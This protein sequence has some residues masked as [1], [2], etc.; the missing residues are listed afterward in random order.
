MDRRRRESRQRMVNDQDG[1]EWVNVSSGTGSPGWSETNGRQRSLLLCL[2]VQLFLR[3]FSWVS[4]T[5]F[6][7][8]VLSCFFAQLFHEHTATCRAI[9]KPQHQYMHCIT[10][11]HKQATATGNVKC[12]VWYGCQKMLQFSLFE[13][14]VQCVRS[15]CS[16][17]LQAALK[18]QRRDPAS[19][20]LCT[21]TAQG[22]SQFGTGQI[23][24]LKRGASLPALQCCIALIIL[25]QRT[26][27]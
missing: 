9:L 6:V 13:L 27:K 4:V 11:K 1:C 22:G 10:Q 5:Y 20:R 15:N 2:L 25:I 24:P 8:H 18:G 3:L 17:R 21:Q 19:I 26:R 14:C 7:V 23:S 12:G 16:E